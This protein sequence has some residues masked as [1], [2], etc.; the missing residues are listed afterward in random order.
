MPVMLTFSSLSCKPGPIT[1]KNKCM[2]GRILLFSRVMGRSDYAN[3]HE[4]S[5]GKA[6]NRVCSR[7]RAH[8]KTYGRPHQLLPLD[9]LGLK[10]IS[11]L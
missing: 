7:Q 5:R 2:K 9:E 8:P 10:P 11:P 3:D 4:N 1:E 6:T